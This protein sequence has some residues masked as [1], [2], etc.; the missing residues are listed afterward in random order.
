MATQQRLK[1]IG[2][3]PIGM[4]T[5]QIAVGIDGFRLKPKAKFHAQ[6]I[7]GVGQPFQT[8]GQL[9]LVYIVVAQACQIVVAVAKPAIIQ[10]KQFAAQ[11]L[12]PAGKP[13]QPIVI[14]VEH[15]AFPIVVQ[16]GSGTVLPFFWHDMIVDKLVHA[17][18]QTAK[19]FLGYG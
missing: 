14:E 7:H 17:S 9:F 5:V 11:L 1:I 8:V 10:H 19:A 6:F 4:G 2:Q 3:R 16:N 12:S 15:A 13:H 18:G